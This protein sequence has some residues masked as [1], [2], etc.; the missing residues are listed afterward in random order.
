MRTA[1]EE[2]LQ[3]SIDLLASHVSLSDPLPTAPITDEQLSR[4]GE[5]LF[6]TE[7]KLPQGTSSDAV[8]THSVNTPPPAA[9]PKRKLND[10]GG[11]EVV[12]TLTTKRSKVAAHGPPQ[13]ADSASLPGVTPRGRGMHPRNKYLEKAPDF[14]ALAA[15]YPE[16]RPYVKAGRK[17]GGRSWINWK[18]FNATRELTRV[19]LLHDFGVEW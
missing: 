12:E 4:S 19:L 1:L 17:G 14:E 6:P 10:R 5:V 2:V 3:L 15:Q 13:Q 9:S 11:E 16:L 7:F 8:A 18:D